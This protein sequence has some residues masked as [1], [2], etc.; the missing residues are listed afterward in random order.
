MIHQ[1]R[2]FLSSTFY[3]MEKERHYFQDIIYPEI[4]EFCKQK[5][6]EFLPID[7]RWGVK[8]DMRLVLQTCFNEIDN[9]RPFFIGI[10]GNK[11]GTLPK[12]EEIDI[13]REY[14]LVRNPDLP[15]TIII[16]GESIT[17]ME[18]D[19]GLLHTP[20]L[21]AVFLVRDKNNT[22]EVNRDETDLTLQKKQEQLRQRILESDYPHFPYSNIEQY[23]VLLKQTILHFIES[24]F[25]ENENIDLYNH[26]QQLIEVYSSNSLVIPEAHERLKQWYMSEN[27]VLFCEGDM[28]GASGWT[29][30]FCQFLHKHQKSGKRALYID[31]SLLYLQSKQYDFLTSY[32]DSHISP[33][34][35]EPVVCIEH[36]ELLQIMT[37]RKLGCFINLHCLHIRFII[38]NRPRYIDDDWGQ[39]MW[40]L[41]PTEQWDELYSEEQ[42]LKI[43]KFHLKKYGKIIPESYW[44]SI[45][46]YGHQRSDDT[47]GKYDPQLGNIITA[48]Q[49]VQGLDKTEVPQQLAKGIFFSQSEIDLG[50]WLIDMLYKKAHRYNIL[51]EV[52]NA[53]TLLVVALHKKEING[54]TEQEIK[55]IANLED[56]K[57][58]MVRPLILPFCDVLDGNRYRVKW[59]DLYDAIGEDELVEKQET[60]LDQYIAAHNLV[61][62]EEEIVTYRNTPYESLTGYELFDKLVKNAHIVINEAI[63]SLPQERKD[64]IIRRINKYPERYP[65]G[66]KQIILNPATSVREWSDQKILQVFISLYNWALINENVAF[67][68][69]CQLF[70]AVAIIYQRQNEQYLAGKYADMARKILGDA[71]YT[72][73]VPKEMSNNLA[74][75]QVL[76]N[77]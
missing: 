13:A 52:Q 28:R 21:N 12:K 9:S 18:I 63:V 62:T 23:G 45:I 15:Q 5:N 3:D 4:A 53:I 34:D 2:L 10:I 75:M 65:K 41:C 6:V 72:P 22:I 55:Q 20:P 56:S 42:R 76:Y 57:W 25:S 19:Y 40:W 74:I 49:V 61:P 7:L 26:Q 31:C 66:Y 58:Y 11:Y 29:T 1:F 54:L 59:K 67:H 24:R 32:I 8:D 60:L 77:V 73:L 46:A 38:H 68:H 17:E 71:L 30:F 35:H 44:D 50:Y 70:A 14:L 27:P 37:L 39:M 36:V 33:E 51:T 16:E 64:N 48:I 47:F 43:V 69:L